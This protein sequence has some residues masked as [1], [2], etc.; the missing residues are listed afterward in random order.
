MVHGGLHA[1]WLCCPLLPLGWE[2]EK[3]RWQRLC[4]L[5]LCSLPLGLEGVVPPLP[6]VVLE[7]EVGA[8]LDEVVEE[9]T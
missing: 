1:E 9:P 6:D 3:D 5:S 2:I 4:C 7:V 8:V